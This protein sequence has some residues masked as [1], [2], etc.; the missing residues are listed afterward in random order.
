MKAGRELKEV[1]FV[2]S[3]CSIIVLFVCLSATWLI[4]ITPNLLLSH[5]ILFPDLEAEEADLADNSII[6]K[7][8]VMN[9]T[10]CL[11]PCSG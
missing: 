1:Y 8:A 10:C 5:A 6:Y 2:F 3:A 7:H 4:T 11:F 9:E